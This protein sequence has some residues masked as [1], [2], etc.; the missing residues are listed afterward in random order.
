MGQPHRIRHL[1]RALGQIMAREGVWQATGAEIADWYIANALPN[2]SGAPGPDCLVR[3]ASACGSQNCTNIHPCR[4]G[5]LPMAK[6]AAY[7]AFH[8]TL[9]IEHW[10]LAPPPGSVKDQRFISEFGPQAPDYRTWTQT[11]N[12]AIVLASS[13]SSTCSTVRHQ[14]ERSHRRIGLRALS[15]AGRRGDTPRLGSA[16]AR[17][18]RNG[19]SSQ[20]KWPTPSSAPT[21]LHRLRLSRA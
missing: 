8:V 6:T 7:A 16:G 10:E 5:A 20:A 13:V 19:E 14:G 3:E 18:A 1:D 11:R 21:S 17:N 12:T 4:Y 15:R 9:F 2:L